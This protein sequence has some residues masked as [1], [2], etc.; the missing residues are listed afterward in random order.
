MTRGR[1]AG[2]TGALALVIPL[3]I[4][5]VI[6]VGG[7]GTGI[8]AVAVHDT[9]WGWPL[10]VLAVVAVVAALGQPWPWWARPLFCL[11]WGATVFALSMPRPDG[12]VVV[13]GDA[14]GYG[15]LLVAVLVALVG[16][17]SAA[18]GRSR[19]DAGEPPP[20]P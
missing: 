18:R 5:L 16:V 8:A 2:L 19:A 17:L 6:V 20:A 10:A 15:L 1:G 12:D 4:P 14:R 3:V 7:A 13:S 11:P 9:A